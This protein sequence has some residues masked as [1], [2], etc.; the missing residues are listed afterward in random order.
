M[1]GTN[2]SDWYNQD[3][4]TF[5]GEL[6]SLGETGVPVLFSIGTTFDDV[7]Y[8]SIAAS[9]VVLTVRS[10]G[11]SFYS[12]PAIALPSDQFKFAVALKDDDMALAVDGGTLSTDTS[13]TIPSPT[14]LTLG[15][16]SWSAG[17][18]ANTHIK[19]FT[20]YPRR[21]TNAELQVLTAE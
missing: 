10:G 16:A 18:Y 2:F 12:G 15:R 8:A 7:T 11:T 17:N 1:A 9:N 14:N 5:V 20:Y 4:G 6:D 13:G 3:E 21:L 19:R